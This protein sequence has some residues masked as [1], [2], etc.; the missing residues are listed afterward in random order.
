MLVF[1]PFQ[2]TILKGNSSTNGLN[3]LK[4]VRNEVIFK[5]LRGKNFKIVWEDDCFPP[6]ATA[7]CP[8]DSFYAC[9][10]NSISL[11]TQEVIPSREGAFKVLNSTHTCIHMHKF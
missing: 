7:Y 8:Y 9:C 11:K 5:Y 4:T 2:W 1:F 3:L 6:L 10:N